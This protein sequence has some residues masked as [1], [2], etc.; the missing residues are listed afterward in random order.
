MGKTI[1]LYVDESFQQALERI[2][3]EVA[4]DFKRKYNLEEVTIPSTL[5]SQILAAKL[6]GQKFLNF[7]IRKNGL[8]K[9]ILVLS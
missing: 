9:G 1:R 6:N 2:R 8:N 3:R 5:T 7:Q 4:L